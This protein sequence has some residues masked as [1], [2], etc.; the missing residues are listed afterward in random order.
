M[1]TRNL[2]KNEARDTSDFAKLLIL[3]G[4]QQESNVRLPPCEGADPRV[5][6][7][8]KAVTN[9]KTG[10]N[11]GT[12]HKDFVASIVCGRGLTCGD[13]PSLFIVIMVKLE[14]GPTFLCLCLRL[15]VADTPPATTS[16]TPNQ[17]PSMFTG[18]LPNSFLPII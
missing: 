7:L 10:P 12:C 16:G 3:R 17:F 14:I 6:L 8:T 4:T 18:G 13:Q 11:D 9:R 15:R 5:T 2:K 1:I